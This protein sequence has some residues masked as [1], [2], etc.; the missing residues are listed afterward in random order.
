MYPRG[1]NYFLSLPRELQLETL[2][3]LS[4]NELHH[5]CLLN[6]KINKISKS[7]EFWNHKIGTYITYQNSNMLV[8]LY[9]AIVSKLAEKA[10]E[11]QNMP[12]KG[13]TIFLNSGIESPLKNHVNF[14]M[15]AHSLE[16]ALLR[17]DKYLET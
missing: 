6:D 7:E 2:L 15:L 5:A 1:D 9:Q 12:L 13:Y 11:N 17:L 10:R 3:R 16:E 4:G 14:M 8:L